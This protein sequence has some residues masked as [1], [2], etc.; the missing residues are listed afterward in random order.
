MHQNDVK[1][2]S[3]TPFNVGSTRIRGCE[4]ASVS[5]RLLIPYSGEFCLISL[6]G[7][8]F[9]RSVNNGVRERLRDMSV[10]EPFGSW[11]IKILV[12]FRLSDSHLLTSSSEMDAGCRNPPLRCTLI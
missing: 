3:L 7:A 2:P 9:E 12:T 8:V 10:S 4:L 11:K 5:V 1:P 6:R